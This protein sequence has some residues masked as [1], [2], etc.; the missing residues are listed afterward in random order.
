V[1]LSAA[2][3]NV[4]ELWRIPGTFTLLVCDPSANWS[5]DEFYKHMNYTGYGDTARY[6]DTFK[7]TIVQ[8]AFTNNYLF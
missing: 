4:G 5:M 6:G 7:Q 2:D 8:Y 3:I 1:K